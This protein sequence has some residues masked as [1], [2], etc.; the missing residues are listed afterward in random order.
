MFS[1]VMDHSWRPRHAWT[2][3]SLIWLLLRARATMRWRR[4]SDL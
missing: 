2:L 4:W 1:L 3:L